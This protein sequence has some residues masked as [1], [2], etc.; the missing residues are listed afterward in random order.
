MTKKALLVGI[1]YNGTPNQ[2]NGCV[3]D[4]MLMNEVLLNKYGFIDPKERRMLVN[5][6][7]T[8]ANIIERLQWLV[9]D[10]Q[11]GDV[12]YFH[13]SGH[14]SQIADI[15]G[16][17]PDGLDEIICPNDLNWRDKIIT[18][19]MLKSIF[20]DVPTG[21]NLTVTLDCCH[22]GSGLKEILNPYTLPS[23]S[24]T[25]SKFVQAPPDIEN[26]SIGLDLEIKPRAVQSSRV[27]YEDQTGILISGCASNQTSADA[28]IQKSNRFQGALTYYLIE[29]LADH[30]YDVKYTILVTDV[31]TKML[32][33]GYAQTPELNCKE[34]YKEL[35]FLQPIV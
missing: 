28:W 20:D 16:D 32:Q 15:N 12:L 11:P 10:A 9:T 1:N 24:P 34:V 7:A 35:K 21:V 14:G 5:E 3:N 22:S 18:D 33:Y 25:K 2:L 6:S 17:E 8:T 23:S 31:N 4:V 26:H 27:S 30:N 19:D 13:Y 29:T